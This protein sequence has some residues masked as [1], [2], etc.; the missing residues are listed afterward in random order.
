[1]PAGGGAK[2]CLFQAAF[3]FFP[4]GINNYNVNLE[5]LDGLN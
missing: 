4:A 5:N 2:S 1:M 3:L